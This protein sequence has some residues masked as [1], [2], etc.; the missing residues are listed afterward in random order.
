MNANRLNS[1][2]NEWHLW[3]WGGKVNSARHVK[4]RWP[5]GD[6]KPPM[7]LNLNR[8]TCQWYYYAAR[9]TWTMYIRGGEWIIKQ[10]NIPVND[11]RKHQRENTVRLRVLAAWETTQSKWSLPSKLGGLDGISSFFLMFKL[12]ICQPIHIQVS[13]TNS[14][15]KK[16]FTHETHLHFQ[17]CKHQHQHNRPWP[18]YLSAVLWKLLLHLLGVL[19]EPSS[20][21]G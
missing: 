7:N 1:R 16:E 17:T 11:W 14:S 2:M 18:K 20:L 6:T 21:G 4:E 8:C 13:S 9:R 3:K 15:P 10:N 19:P 5:P 12:Y